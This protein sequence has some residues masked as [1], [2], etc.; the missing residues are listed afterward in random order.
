[1]TLLALWIVAVATSGTFGGFIYILPILAVLATLIS[2][3]QSRRIASCHR[4]THMRSLSLQGILLVVLGPLALAYQ[5]V[6]YMH[7]E[8]AFDVGPIHV[9]KNSQEHISLSPILG[10]VALVGGDSLLIVGARQET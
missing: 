1:M 2:F 8:K 10:G 6:T 5:G 3:I 9:T 7:R 4:G